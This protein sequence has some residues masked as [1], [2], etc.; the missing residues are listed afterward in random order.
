MFGVT[1]LWQSTIDAVGEYA[2]GAAEGLPERKIGTFPQ[3]LY[4][5]GKAKSW[6]VISMKQDWKRIFTFEQGISIWGAD[7]TRQGIITC[8]DTEGFCW[9]SASV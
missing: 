5:E 6:N 1:V 7:A 9:Q 4:D 3:S 2:Y 8:Q